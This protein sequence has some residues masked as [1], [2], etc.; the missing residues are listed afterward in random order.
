MIELQFETKLKPV[1]SDGGGEYRP[2]SNLILSQGLL[3]RVFYPHT[4][5]QNGQVKRKNRYVV[6]TG[7]TLLAHSS[8]PLS[9]WPYAF[10]TATHLIN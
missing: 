7:L 8:V 10:Q 3:H 6:E 4:P 2:L 9:F 5:Q 1:Q